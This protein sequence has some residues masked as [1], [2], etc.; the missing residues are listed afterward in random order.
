[1]NKA[2]QPHE[3]QSFRILDTYILL[4]DLHLLWSP[5]FF[6][7]VTHPFLHPFLFLDHFPP[8]DLFRHLSAYSSPPIPTKNRIAHR[9]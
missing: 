2:L 3:E 1:M 7:F 9:A 8:V 5:P 6:P 4:P